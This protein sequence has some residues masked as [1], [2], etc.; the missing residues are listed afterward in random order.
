ML[1]RNNK[2][3]GGNINFH[4]CNKLIFNNLLLFIKNLKVIFLNLHMYIYISNKELEK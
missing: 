1:D 2:T 4:T 3:L